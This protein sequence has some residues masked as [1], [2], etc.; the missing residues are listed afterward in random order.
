MTD[1][2]GFNSI[3]VDQKFKLLNGDGK[4]YCYNKELAINGAPKTIWFTASYWMNDLPDSSPFPLCDPPNACSPKAHRIKIPCEYLTETIDDWIVFKI[5]SH[6]KQGN[7]HLHHLF[8][9]VNKKDDKS[10]DW[11]KQNIEES[12]KYNI[13]GRDLDKPIYFE[14]G[15]LFSFGIDKYHVVD[16]AF[17]HDF[18]DSFGK[19]EFDTV[20]HRCPKIKSEL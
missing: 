15:E 6:K 14:N 16:I 18:A 11:Y 7:D 17:S 10:K 5:G 20:T 12:K 9:F 2:Q 13:V 3:K 1:E 8:Y 4:N 19:F